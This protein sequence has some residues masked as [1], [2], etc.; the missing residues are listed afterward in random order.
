MI[1][2]N[3]TLVGDAGMATREPHPD[4]TARPMQGVLTQRVCRSMLLLFCRAGLRLLAGTTSWVR[5][6]RV[7]YLHVRAWE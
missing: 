3:L 4:C 2:A 5:L 1:L 6:G 7:L